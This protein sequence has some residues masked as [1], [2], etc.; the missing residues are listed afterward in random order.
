MR[1]LIAEEVSRRVLE[2]TL[3]K[4]GY[5]VVTTHDGE[6]AWRVL[7]REDAPPLAI[8][9]WMMPG[10]DGV[11]VCRRVVAAGRAVRPYLVPLTA[12]GRG[13]ALVEGLEAGAD[14]YVVKPF[15]RAELRA[16]LRVGERTVALQQHL[17]TRV[18][19]LEAALAH[20]C[21]LQDLLPMCAWC[22]KIRD[23]QNYWQDLE[24][25][26]TQHSDTRFTHG[27]CPECR[28]RVRGSFS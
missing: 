12:K 13:Q 27:I 16:R 3:G 28:A 18:T 19:E 17:A 23:D 24:S 10:L 8:L 1:V 15:D 25:Y 6:A 7:E 14:D 26:V 2:A 5:E 20:I 22:R 9:D 11:E 4:W 21:R